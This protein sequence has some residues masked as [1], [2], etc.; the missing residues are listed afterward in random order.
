MMMVETRLAGLVGMV[1]STAVAAATWRSPLELVG[2]PAPVVCMAFAGVAIGQVVQPPKASRLAM[3]GL[4]LAY[5]FFSAVLAMLLGIVPHMEWTRDAAPL[6]AGMLGFFAQVT[7]PATRGRLQ[8]EIRGND[9]SGG[10][11]P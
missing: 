7:V 9:S 10:E 5:T 1:Y 4:T 11:T 6:I 8:R 3:F 2:L